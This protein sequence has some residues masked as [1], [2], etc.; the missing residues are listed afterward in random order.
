VQR[1]LIAPTSLHRLRRR[2]LAAGPGVAAEILHE[3][4]YGTGEALAAA[5]AEHVRKRTGLSDPGDLDAGWLGPLLAE[6]CREMGWGS[7]ELAAID[8]RALV[9]S[10][11]DWAEAEPGATAE[12]AC[13]F[14]CGALAAFFTAVAGSGSA[15]PIAVIE[16]AC[17]SRGDDR[18]SFLA[19]GRDA[20][21]AVYDLMAAGRDWREAFA[22]APAE[23]TIQ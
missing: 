15:S 3:A 23:R 13:Y 17:R 7:L 8:E 18:C 11:V 1:Y 16:V 9:V 6:L 12:P 22:P 5:W 20:L 10:S 14:S 2:L 21:A 19:A 4:G